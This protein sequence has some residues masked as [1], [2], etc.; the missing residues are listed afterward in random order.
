MVS[1]PRCPADV[2][3]AFWDL[4]YSF[5]VHVWLYVHCFVDTGILGPGSKLFSCPPFGPLMDV[6]GLPL[7][8]WPTPGSWSSPSSL[9]LSSS[10]SSYI[11]FIIVYVHSQSLRSFCFSLSCD[12][13]LLFSPKNYFSFSSSKCAVEVPMRCLYVADSVP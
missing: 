11:I 9:S 1:P 8:R 5:D 2:T 10:L 13:I 12:W 3:V 6:Y 4:P 7:R